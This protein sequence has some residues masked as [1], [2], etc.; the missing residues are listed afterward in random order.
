[1][2]SFCPL[3]PLMAMTGGQSVAISDAFGRV[4]LEVPE[5]ADA[6]YEGLGEFFNIIG[7]SYRNPLDMAGTV[8]QDPKNLDR[9]L[10]IIN[11][12]PGIDALAM[13]L[14]ATFMARRWADKPEEFER[15]LDSIKAFQARSDKPLITILHPSHVEAAALDARQKL[16]A[17][18]IAVFQSFERAA[19]AMAKVAT[20]RAHNG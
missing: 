10:D 6:S 1:M 9:I 11:D 2:T 18:D 19:S 5:L 12:D 17:R 3:D 7:G 16:Q 20:R 15:L 4:G 14:S 8:S 13:E